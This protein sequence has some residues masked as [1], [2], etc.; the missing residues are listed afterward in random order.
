MVLTS[1]NNI[2]IPH[3]SYICI[4]PGVSSTLDDLISVLATNTSCHANFHQHFL[5]LAVQLLDSTN[6]EGLPLGLVAVS[7]CVI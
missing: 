6:K 4:D 1:L 3:T 2:L 5:P 7:V